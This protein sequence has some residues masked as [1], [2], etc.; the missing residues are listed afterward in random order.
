MGNAP[1]HP[2]LLSTLREATERGIVV[3][4]LTQCISGQVVSIW[5]YAT[6][7]ALADVGVI[8]GYDM[9]FLKQR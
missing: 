9:T 4:N 5:G 1:S 3:V 8:S 2:A 6:G 7:Q